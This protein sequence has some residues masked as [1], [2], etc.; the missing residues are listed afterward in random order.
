MLKVLLPIAAC[1][2]S[3]IARA[4]T[5]TCRNWLLDQQQLLDAANIQDAGSTA[6]D[7]FPHLRTNRWLA[8]LQQEVRTEAQ[9][10]QWL[11]L[12]S[13]Q[14]RLHWRA[15]L[16]RLHGDGDWRDTLDTCL[17]TLTGF[18]AFPGVP[19]VNVADSYSTS[20]RVF[21]VYALTR[22]LAQ[23]GINRYRADMASRFQRSLRRPA[24]YFMPQPF[25]GEPPPP[26]ELQVNPLEV[27]NPGP[28]A[29]QALFS[30]YAPILA[31][32]DEAEHNQIGTLVARQD[33]VDLDSSTPSSYAWLS[34][35]RYRGHNLLQINYLYWFSERPAEGRLDPYAGH[36]DGLIWR[37]TLKPDGH[38]LYYDS[39]HAC[40][41]YHK[42]YP[43]ARGLAAADLPDA[44]V[45][46]NRLAP[47][48]KQ[49]RV[50]VH[51]EPDTH[52]VVGLQ[53]QSQL[54]GDV[55]QQLYP[56]ADVN[57]LRALRADGGRYLSL[58]DERGLVPGSERGE[59]WFL[60][61]LGVPSAGT[62]RQPGQ[63]ATAFIGRRHFDDPEL[64]AM[65][66][67]QSLTRR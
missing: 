11:R 66:F 28:G 18:S 22:L 23:P 48:A 9:G 10:E 41:C 24:R 12:A 7:G 6:I 59:R 36:L 67:A 31:V 61:P 2:L 42:V 49:Q 46:Y 50:I 21:G 38:V 25:L 55:P 63:H 17:Q 37:V 62:M 39:I 58:F 4:D 16:S 1:L 27:P 45:F 14:A 51:L 34:T 30:Y 57:T 33:Q 3:L 40:G 8:L 44:P 5:E 53:R 54:Q 26:S 29:T 35:T 15:V 65:I 52:Y 64:P 20:Q 13:E 32:A 60:W 43:V 47:N 19:E 56:F